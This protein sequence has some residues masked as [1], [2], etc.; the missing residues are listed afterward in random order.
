MWRYYHLDVQPDLFGSF[1]AVREWGRI[2]RRGRLR[3]GPGG[4][5]AR[6]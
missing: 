3:D 4:S 2:G 6:A 5:G 1:G